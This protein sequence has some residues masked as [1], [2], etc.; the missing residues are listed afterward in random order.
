[1]GI[2][3]QWFS[4]GRKNITTP[5]SNPRNASAMAVAAHDTDVVTMTFNDRS[6]TY[7]GDLASY[8]YDNILKSKQK[9]ITRL[10]E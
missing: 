7:S 8:D 6:I 9:N 1:M 10:F 4:G 2:F 5:I 3:S